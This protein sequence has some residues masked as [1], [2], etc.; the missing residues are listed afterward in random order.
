MKSGIII[1]DNYCES[2][3][4]FKVVIGLCWNNEIEVIDFK[5]SFFKKWDQ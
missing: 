2:T 4:Y 3:S 1:F 5:K